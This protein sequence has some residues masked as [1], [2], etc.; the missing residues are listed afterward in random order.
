M[1]KCKNCGYNHDKEK[2]TCE[3]VTERVNILRAGIELTKSGFAGIMPNGNIVDRREFPNAVP[4]QKNTMFG[5]PE[6]KKLE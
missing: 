5:T 4:I 3:Q 6:P 2:E 1:E